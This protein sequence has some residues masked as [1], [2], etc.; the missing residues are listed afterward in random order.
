[1]PPYSTNPAV[2]FTGKYTARFVGRRLSGEGTRGVERGFIETIRFLVSGGGILHIRVA[3]ILN[4][5]S[6]GPRVL[7]RLKAVRFTSACF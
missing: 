3:E 2:I 7:S 1:M 6:K 5:E 4:S